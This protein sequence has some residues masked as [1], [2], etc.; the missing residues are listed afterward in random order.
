[1]M[2]FIVSQAGDVYQRD[3]GPETARRA[4]AIVTF[5]PDKD[6][7]KADMTPP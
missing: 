3:L 2:T 5:N 7:T 4:A 1:V 6:W